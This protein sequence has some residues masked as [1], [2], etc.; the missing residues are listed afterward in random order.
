MSVRVEGAVSGG[1]GEEEGGWAS[2]SVDAVEDGRLFVR[3]LS[4]PEC[5]V[6]L[7]HLLSTPSSYPCSDLFS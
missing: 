2:K 5:G 7:L 6:H 1:G 3:E 4:R